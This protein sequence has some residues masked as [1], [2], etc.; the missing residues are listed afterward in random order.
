MRSSWKLP[1]LLQLT[2]NGS[3]AS[4]PM[5]IARWMPLN[6]QF[7]N[8]TPSPCVKEIAV[9]PLTPALM[10]QFATL[11]M[12]LQLMNLVY[13]DPSL[14]TNRPCQFAREWLRN[15]MFTH[16]DPSKL[17]VVTSVES[18]AGG[19]MRTP[20]LPEYTPTPTTR[21]L[22]AAGVRLAS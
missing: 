12:N 20:A 16:V 9:P 13:S 14:W 21:T 19:W 18:S 2:M 10:G 22:F 11:F 7:S 4:R 1:M 3:D 17:D 6:S 5:C 8:V 15:W